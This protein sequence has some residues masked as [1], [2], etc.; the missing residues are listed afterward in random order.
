MHVRTGGHNRRY[1]TVEACVKVDAA[2]IRRAGLFDASRFA[3]W[4]WNY[5]SAGEPSHSIVAVAG[6]WPDEIVLAVVPKGERIPAQLS[7]ELIP[8]TLPHGQRVKISHT[9]CNYG[10]RRAW[11]HCPLCDRRVFRLYYYDNTV[12]K[13][14]RVHFLACRHCN[15]LTYELR[16]ARGFALQQTR[17]EHVRGKIIAR[18]GQ[19]DELSGWEDLPDKPKGMHLSTYERHLEK[20]EGIC[21]LADDAFGARLA[22]LMERMK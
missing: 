19:D 4:H 15:H 5:R 14:K 10:K 1:A 9:T 11:L 13:G 12:S 8:G 18:G 20:F 22:W 16:Q 6:L 21:E 2:M 17:A 7:A 3:A